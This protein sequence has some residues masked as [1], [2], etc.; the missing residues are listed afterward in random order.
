[1]TE[2]QL[3]TLINFKCTTNDTTFPIAS[4]LALINT[5]KDEICSMIVE[6]NNGMFLIPSTFD[7]VEDQREYAI[8]DDLL[9]RVHKVELKFSADG[10]RYPSRGIK[11]YQGSESESEI[12]QKFS[13]AEGCFAHTI[14]RRAL[15]ILSG[16]IPDVTDGGR[17]WAH[18][19]PAD[20]TTLTGTANDL[21]K[22]PSTTSFGFPRQFHELL[23][24]RVGIEYK[25]SKNKPIPLSAIEK[26]YENDL[27][28]QLNA[29]SSVDNSL[30]VIADMP[31]ASHFWNNGHNL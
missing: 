23:A 1:M 24:R 14:R 5:F 13:N 19:Y 31:D 11:D 29:I 12:I 4:K 2:A 3:N 18:I 9:N 21:S 15:F 27:A 26:N 16:A 6:K 25:C 30:E 8:G 17:I 20:L 28:V 22:D 10:P 7:L